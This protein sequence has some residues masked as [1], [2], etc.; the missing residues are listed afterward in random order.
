MVARTL[1]TSRSKTGKTLNVNPLWSWFRTPGS[2][3]IAWKYRKCHQ[4]GRDNIVLDIDVRHQVIM[5][6]WHG[7]EQIW[8][9]LRCGWFERPWLYCDI[10]VFERTFNWYHITRQWGPYICKFKFWLISTHTAIVMLYVLLCYFGSRFTCEEFI[11]KYRGCVNCKHSHRPLVLLWIATSQHNVFSWPSNDSS[12][13]YQVSTEPLTNHK[14]F[15]CH[16]AT[17]N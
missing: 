17:E 3:T 14:L 9:Q 5:T 8:Q 10:N 12:C 4:M 1:E 16:W 6:S 11:I 15:Y 2:S 13:A 7:N